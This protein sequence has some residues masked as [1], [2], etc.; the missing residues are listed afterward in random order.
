MIVINQLR[1]S[2][3]QPRIHDIRTIPDID[4]AEMARVEA[5]LKGAGYRFIGG[6]T[7]DVYDWTTPEPLTICWSR[8]TSLSQGEG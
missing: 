4:E 3:S 5:S 8:S 7:C 1:L 6:A 2:S